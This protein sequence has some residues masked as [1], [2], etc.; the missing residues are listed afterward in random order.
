MSV[1]I[2]PA[3][4]GSKRFPGKNTL[5]FEGE[6]LVVRA[7]RIA[8][9]SNTFSSVIVNTD[10]EK[11]FPLFK[12]VVG[13]LVSNRP[14]E[15]GADLVRADDV[16]RWQILELG[17]SPHETICCLLPTTPGLNS[18]ELVTALGLF[19]ENEKLSPL[20]GVV[21]SFQSPFRTFHMEKS[22]ELRPLF[23]TMLDL[24]SQEYPKTYSDAGHF[25]FATAE[26]WLETFSITNHPNSRGYILSNTRHIDINTIEDWNL[27]LSYS[28][29]L[30][31]RLHET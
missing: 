3:R 4:K 15:L 9:E 7:A 22:N 19:E 13:V 10:D 17:I 31:D 2:I 18:I 11:I 6:P 12:D 26:Q 16:I 25:Y 21:E 28:K 14:A 29:L 20:F 1:C 24:Q 8:I 5:L 23:P 30:E 27:F